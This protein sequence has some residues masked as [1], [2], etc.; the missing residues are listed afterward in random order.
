MATQQQIIQGQNAKIM[1]MEQT[2]HKARTH[3]KSIMAK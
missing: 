2:A 3:N 1:A